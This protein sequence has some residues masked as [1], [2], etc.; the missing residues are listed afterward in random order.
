MNKFLLDTHIFLWSLLNPSFLT[1]DV[2]NELENPVNELWISPITTWEIIILNEKNLIELD[3]HPVEWI[4][5][6]L[7]TLPFKEAALNH[8]VAMQSRI[9]QL[10][11]QDPVDRFIV[12]TALVYG[13]TLITADRNLIE[14][15]QN[16]SIF[17]NRRGN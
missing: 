4:K 8:E 3:D 10:P 15:A 17:P 11:H 2:S 6:V 5:N 9:I 7:A 16:F 14:N 13:L 1:E 12:A